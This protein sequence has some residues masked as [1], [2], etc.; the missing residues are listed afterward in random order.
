MTRDIDRSLERAGLPPLERSAWIEVDTDMLTGNASSLRALSSPAALGAVVKADGYGHGLEMTA[1][2]AVTGG[3]EWLCVADAAEAG[4]LRRDGYK[5]K[6]FVLY[7]VPAAILPTMAQLRVDVSIGSLEEAASIAGRPTSDDRILAVHIEVDTGMTRGGV[8]PDDVIAAATAIVEA[9]SAS[10]AGVWT[11]LAAPE[12]PAK[13]DE[14]LSH[15]D[16][17]LKELATAGMDAGAVHAAASGGLLAVS[18]E[19]H[20]FVRPGLALYGYHPGAGDPLPPN[21]APALAV[22]AHPVRITEIPPG[23]AVG[24]AGT[25]TAMRV[26]TIATL[27]IG[28]ADGWSRSSSPGTTVLVE[29][30]RAPVVGRVSSD[31]LTVDVTGIAGVNLDSEFTLLGAESGDEITADAIADVRGTISWEVLQQLGARLARVYTSGSVPTALRPESTITIV[32]APGASIP[33]Y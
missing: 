10:L 9:L 22:K 25:W 13:T 2:C 26:S 27:P 1:R 19:E 17:V 5:G 28:Y 16:S 30:Q 29:G 15:F 12:D 18:T 32:M 33:S 11:H 8:A 31:S 14:Q 6:T 7:P 4:R 3:A 23:T 21:V 20:A 24:Y